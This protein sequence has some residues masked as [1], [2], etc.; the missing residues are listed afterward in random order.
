MTGWDMTGQ[1]LKYF[2][3]QYVDQLKNALSG[4]TLFT[5]ILQQTGII[6]NDRCN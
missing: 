2:F 5:N 4:L 3:D 6:D 1:D